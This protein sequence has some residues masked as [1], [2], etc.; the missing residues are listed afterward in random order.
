VAEEEVVP[1]VGVLPPPH[2]DNE[3]RLRVVNGTPPLYLFLVRGVLA[4]FVT[5]LLLSVLC[6]RLSGSFRWQPTDN[7]DEPAALRGLNLSVATGQLVM[8]VGQVGAGMTAGW[9]SRGW[10]NAMV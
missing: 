1:T 10:C 7:K 3:P 2:S 5:G 9:I 8:I 4:L 6:L